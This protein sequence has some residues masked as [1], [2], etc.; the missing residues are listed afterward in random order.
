VNY[1]L[2]KYRDN[3]KKIL[4][5]KKAEK[6]PLIKLCDLIKR[7]KQPEYDDFIIPVVKTVNIRNN[8]I[9][10]DECLT[11]NESFYN[12]SNLKLELNDILLASTGTG[13]VG[14]LAQ[15][16]NNRK[17][18]VDGHITVIRIKKSEKINPQYVYA[19]LNSE[20]GQLQIEQNVRGT[21]GQIEIYP[22]DIGKIL[23]PMPSID[24][25]NK[26]ADIHNK[27]IADKNMYLKR[28]KETLEEIEQ[29][30]IEELN[31]PAQ[32]QNKNVF[33]IKNKYLED[34]QCRLDP[35]YFDFYYYRNF[36]MVIENFKYSS[37]QLKN[38][39]FNTTRKL[40]PRLHE[41]DCFNVLSVN[42]DGQVKFNEK[43]KGKD[44]NQVYKL[45]KEDDVVYNPYRFNIG[46]IGVVSKDLEDGLVSPAYVVFRTDER[47]NPYFLIELLRTSF[48]KKYINIIG[49]GSVRTSISLSALGDIY[50]PLPNRNVQQY[51]YQQCEKLRKTIKEI[52]NKYVE[53]EKETSEKIKYILF[54]E[55][56][57]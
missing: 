30:I 3:I 54:E 39:I 16:I 17:A 9:I 4:S 46:S 34:K 19:I 41:E 55:T 33:M 18:V 21:T 12:N 6:V 35:E 13:S 10:W 37:I 43:K 14:K 22:D 27:S 24:I 57:K 49:T 20:F 32:K 56:Y 52:N 2:P 36:K 25:Q 42:N 40:D 29:F 23:I 31:L 50:I 7:G 5:I 45:V 53:V 51:I 47:L 38:M 48:Y 44:F 8:R 1:Y 11:V 26:I 15:F 28:S